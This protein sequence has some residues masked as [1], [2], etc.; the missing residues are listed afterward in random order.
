MVPGLRSRNL[1]GRV[2][3]DPRGSS[4]DEHLGQCVSTAP[5]WR[6]KEPRDVHAQR[7]RR[8][9]WSRPKSP[10]Q[11]V[12]VGTLHRHPTQGWT[13][14]IADGPALCP[15]RRRCSLKVKHFALCS[16]ASWPNSRCRTK[17]RAQQ[18]GGTIAS[19]HGDGNQGPFHTSRRL[20][21]RTP[22]KCVV[23]P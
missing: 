4:S 23:Y 9:C 17:R 7:D 1:C 3:S 19:P 13:W 14:S 16:Q 20:W 8:T 2:T 5:S 22:C 21:P 11:T 6:F 15:L 10:P 18:G 12:W